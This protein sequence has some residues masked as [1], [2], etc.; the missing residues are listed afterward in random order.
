MK[1]M[2]DPA[3]ERLEAYL[4]QVRRSLASC[5]GVDAGEVAGDVR[6]HVDEALEGTSEPV[7]LERLEDVLDDLGA[8]ARW[9]PDE[10]LGGFRRVVAR[11][12]E[13]PED[14][15]LGYLCLAVTVIA[16]LT[17]PVGGVLLLIPAFVL[18][19]GALSLAADRAEPVGAQRWLV[20][21]VLILVYA[22]AL[23]VLLVLPVPLSPAVFATGGLVEFLGL[24]YPEPGTAAHWR[25]SA[26]WTALGTGVWWSAW[27]GIAAG[28]PPAVRAALRPFA[29]RFRR[30]H[31]WG[32]ILPGLIVAIAGLILITFS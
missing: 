23:V 32:L 25:A 7:A 6:A 5:P 20:Y 21:P 22:I 12:R 4:S 10:E 14:W 30:R 16:I 28:K 8:P 1:T 27:G 3:R 31:A 13:G 18:A 11:L 17:A 15:R 9:V 19:R 29:D 2:T 24:A 26:G